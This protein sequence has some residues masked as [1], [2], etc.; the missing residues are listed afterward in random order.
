MNHQVMKALIVNC[1]LKKSPSDSNT[2]AVAQILADELGSR[3]VKCEFVRAVDFDILPGV[4]S[5]EGEGD[6]WPKIR[7]KILASEILILASPTWV[8]RLASPAQRVI[9][10]LDAFLFEEDGQG[11]PIAYNHVAGFVA[12]G[13]EDGAKHVIAEMEAA[14][15]E[16]GFSVPGQAWTYWNNGAALGKSYLESKDKAGKE[17]T[18][19][20]AAMA[21]SNI[22]A[23][24]R[25]LQ[26]QPIPTP[27]K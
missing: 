22:V 8:G 17:R 12:T 20:N 24:A 23:M 18:A 16:I 13:N 2:H 4:S 14:L 6:E 3:G 21:A 19:K 10:R 27:P 26:A 7:D 15:L 1:T 11:R 5:D 25:A 9:E